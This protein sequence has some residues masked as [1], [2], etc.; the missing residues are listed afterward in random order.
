MGSEKAEFYGGEE[1]KK[2]LRHVS[3]SKL[4]RIPT[5]A[6]NALQPVYAMNFC[7]YFTLYTF[8]IDYMH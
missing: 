8:S 6:R 2:V 7:E 3:F 5:G 1:P 4:F